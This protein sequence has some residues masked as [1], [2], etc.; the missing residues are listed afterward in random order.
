MTPTFSGSQGL[1]RALFVENYPHT[2]P[3]RR[4][5]VVWHS[6]TVKNIP[7]VWAYFA[8]RRIALPL[9]QKL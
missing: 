2:N 4:D 6:A 1:K 7:G 8:C 5:L 9:G 3:L